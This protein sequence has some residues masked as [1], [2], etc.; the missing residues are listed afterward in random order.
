MY[1]FFLIGGTQSGEQVIFS[2]FLDSFLP[3]LIFYIQ[4]ALSHI[5][6]KMFI[7]VHTLIGWTEVWFTL[8]GYSFSNKKICNHFLKTSLV[9][10]SFGK[11]LKIQQ[12]S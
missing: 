12:L 6:V 8:L 10:G 3:V 4:C 1:M 7:H 11:G 2:Y 5:F 9:L